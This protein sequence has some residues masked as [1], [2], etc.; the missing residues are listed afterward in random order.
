MERDENYVP[1][2]RSQ[3]GLP[4]AD[5]AKEADYTEMFEDAPIVLL[6]RMVVMQLLGLQLYFAFNLLGSPMYPAGT[7]VCCSTLAPVVSI[8]MQS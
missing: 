7:N 1:K 8:L 5:K 2:T 4:P 3:Y 6:Y